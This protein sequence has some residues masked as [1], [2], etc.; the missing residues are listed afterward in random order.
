MKKRLSKKILAAFLAVM[1]VI[2]ALPMSVFAANGYVDAE[3]DAAVTEVK[4]AMSEFKSKLA[5]PNAAYSN[6]TPA[7]Q[8]YVNC[9][10]GL[11]AY[12]YGGK[13]TALNGLADKLTAAM[14]AMSVF[15]GASANTDKYRTTKVFPADSTGYGSEDYAKAYK[16]V[17]WLETGIDT[18]G[19]D[20][21]TAAEN[22]SAMTLY[23]PEATLMYD[24]ITDPATAIM[25]IT[26]GEGDAGL[27]RT[28]N[29]YVSAI[30]SE[31]NDFAL[32]SNWHG[33]AGNN[34]DF[35]WSWITNG[36]SYNLSNDTSKAATVY[37]IRSGRRSYSNKYFANL[38][39]FKNGASTF[40]TG[41][42][43]KLK[44]DVIPTLKAHIGSSNNFA[45]NI[46]DASSPTVTGTT[47]IHVVNYKYVIDAIKL[48]GSKMKGVDL[49]E[50]SEGSLIQYIKAMDAA[51]AFEP[52]SYFASSNDIDGYCRAASTVVS[53]MNS[54]STSTTNSEAWQ[55]LRD[56]MNSHVRQTYAEGGD[57]YT[58]ESWAKFVETYETVRNYFANINTTEFT[59][60][61]HYTDA[62]TTNAYAN[63]ITTA[64]NGLKTNVAKV[65]TT[66][67]V[68]AIKT[69]ESYDANFFTT[70]SYKPVHATVNDVKVAVWGSADNWG[71]PA[72]APDDDEAGAGKALVASNLEKLNDAIATL[73]IS[74]AYNTMTTQGTTSLDAVLQLENKVTNPRD[75]SNYASF[76]NALDDANV[77][78]AKLADT[79]LTDYDAQYDEYA[80]TVDAVITAYNALQYSFTKI[81]DGTIFANNNSNNI[82][83]ITLKDQGTQ[84]VEGDYTGF[85][86]VF[87]TKHEAMDVDFGKLNV[88]FGT[89]INSRI[90]NSLDSISIDATAPKL[91]D[92]NSKAHIN[93]DGW[94]STPKALTDE[95]KETYKAVL[96]TGKIDEGGKGF[97]VHG[98]KY[99]GNNNFNN[100]DYKIVTNNGTQINDYDTALT[101]D[102]DPILGETT[103]S[104]Q[105]P[106]Y[107]AIFARSNGDDNEAKIF[108]SGNLGFHIPATTKQEL[109]ATTLPASKVYDMTT[110][111]G[112]VG[113]WNCTNTANYCGYN[114][115][116]SEMTDTYFTPSVTI[117]D[118]SSLVELVDLANAKLDDSQMYS[119]A[120]WSAFTKALE[121][122]QA[123]LSYSNIKNAS[124]LRNLVTAIQQRYTNLWNA[125][126][127]LEVKTLNLTFNYKDASAADA[128]TVVKVQ[129]GKNVT[130]TAADQFNAIQTPN[131]VDG[132]Y[133]YSFNGWTPTFDPDAAVTEDA[134]YTALYD[135]TINAANWDAFNA[136][137]N[138]L[139]D[140]IVDNKFTA[141]AL[142]NVAGEL[143]KLT[144]FDYTDDQKADVM[145]DAQ[146]VIDAETATLTSLA[147]SLVQ[148]NIETSA[149]DALKQMQ[150]EKGYTDED[151]YD[152]LSKTFA[153]TKDVTVASKTVKGFLYDSQTALDA[154]IAAALNDI[155]V[156]TYDV[157]LNG[158][159]IGN[160]AYG[161][162]I[163][164]DANGA[165][166]TGT[167]TD[168]KEGAN[169]A[170][171]Y[172][173]AAPSN[174]NTPTTAKYMITA[175]TFGFVVKGTTYLTTKAV[176]DAASGYTVTI[177]SSVNGKTLA[178]VTTKADGTFTM[179]TV[180]LPFYTFASYSNGVAAGAQATVSENKVITAYFNPV[181]DT[182]AK[183]TVYVFNSM[184][185]FEGATNPTVYNDLSYNQLVNVSIPG[186]YAIVKSVL[187]ENYLSATN[188]ILTYGD[189]YSFY[190][191]SS[192]YQD[193]GMDGTLVAIVGL[194]EQQY[195]D[196]QSSE[197]D[198]HL[199]DGQGNQIVPSTSE[200][201]KAPQADVITREEPVYTGDL[202]KFS[203]IGT[204]VAPEGYTMIE[205]GFL[206]TN[207]DTT[208]DM[209]V[210][211]VGK[212]GIR[213]LKASKYTVGNQFVI[214]I[215]NPTAEHNFK[216]TAYSVMQKADG[217]KI[218]VYGKTVS[219]SNAGHVNNN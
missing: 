207:N 166:T 146:S 192:Y 139:V 56:A 57:K 136:A 120:S 212:N 90:N 133:T 100:S 10:Q 35:N 149:A 211:N 143:A 47:K 37:Q 142:E 173:Y 104:A 53:T 138:A 84:F 129:Y 102:L 209:T 114:W 204:F 208:T 216:Y 215:K 3:N 92:L 107:G 8:A 111:F 121:D 175:P 168:T 197:S 105:S 97:F 218:T 164:V 147:A 51:T 23:Y 21:K 116:T 99:T 128:S 65:D 91:G 89:T 12:I 95:Q 9:Q 122:A 203:L 24:G 155:K 88:T 52:S 43:A 46:N 66:A 214:N 31:S 106:I 16:N 32:D 167:T 110:R 60:E 154:A 113:S 82:S 202:A 161:T 158:S 54:A 180:S 70:A 29:R 73:R 125:Y 210:E 137:K 64:Y 199:Y 119:D 169:Y 1:M 159:V 109:S 62:D 172:S 108:T 153:D 61:T 76:K 42:G 196:Y 44:A 93:S 63:A 124:A 18:S 112:A 80:A 14:N 2:T 115:Y 30:V 150:T 213:R 103:G 185:D 171:T 186:A 41:V 49:S 117:V 194:S 183:Y 190:V 174:N 181:E 38:L 40:G 123:N 68:S 200:L 5:E 25:A 179:P 184:D 74:S 130:E 79:V 144:Y 78:Y 86:F 15:T 219:T 148:V 71:V 87:R 198:R 45:N 157:Y 11:D 7:Y 165:I 55:A 145:A 81:P 188:T 34:F 189:K 19:N 132:S 85:A 48:N 67:L 156:K 94:T 98:L 101:T 176:N 50:Y 135:S 26:S 69:F 126:N 17:L 205:S 152:D 163:S 151:I 170:W 28:K 193:D 75:Y 160:V 177:V 195:Q 59:T 191:E 77:Y 22:F 4:N 27:G 127:A 140:K 182:T 217:T 96:D 134:T 187:N 13:E 178:V 118:I 20:G 58:A 201:Y 6:V 33:T 83:R 162:P 39:V 36:D 131:Y 72:Y 206:F 141:A